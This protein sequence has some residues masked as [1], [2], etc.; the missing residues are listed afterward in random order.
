MP[1]TITNQKQ[2]QPA[3][4]ANKHDKKIELFVY[5]LT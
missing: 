1:K 3:M 5:F 4:S 2:G